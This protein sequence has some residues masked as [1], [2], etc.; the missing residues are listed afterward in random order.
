M[1]WCFSAAAMC[2][3]ISPTSRKAAIECTSPA[4]SPVCLLMPGIT[5]TWIPPTMRRR[6]PIR[7]ARDRDE[8]D[9]RHSD[10]EQVEDAVVPGAGEP[11][12]CRELRRI[13]RRFIDQAVG[14]A[15]KHDH[16]DRGA[17][18]LVPD[19]DVVAR[20]SVIRRREGKTE[21]RLEEHEDHGRPVEGRGHVG[22]AAQRILL[23]GFDHAIGHGC[24]RLSVPVR[25]RTRGNE[26]QRVKLL[27][28]CGLI[29]QQLREAE[30]G[31]IRASWRFRPSTILASPT[32]SAQNIGPPR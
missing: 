7:E 16:E 24:L 9:D 15:C 17:D 4:S 13:G 10:Q 22:I 2:R 25:Q 29:E 27:A 28:L 6:R 19:E 26:V 12:P 1:N 3:T 32:E 30:F 11:L 20:R 5:G 14:Q 23:A 8:A 21:I 31:L 18:G